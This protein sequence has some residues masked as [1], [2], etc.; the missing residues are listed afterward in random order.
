MDLVQTKGVKNTKMLADFI[1]E[2]P[3]SCLPCLSRR[4]C[5]GGAIMELWTIYGENDREFPLLGRS[6]LGQIQ[7]I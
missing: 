1:S 6:L 3:P 5:W 4:K 2:W 7:N